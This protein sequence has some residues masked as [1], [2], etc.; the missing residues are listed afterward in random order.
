MGGTVVR[1]PDAGP[2]KALLGSW[3]RAGKERPNLVSATI[4]TGRLASFFGSGSPPGTDTEVSG[5]AAGAGVGV[6]NASP[7]LVDFC[8]S[9]NP[10]WQAR[11]LL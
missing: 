7:P 4:T 8:D 9:Q 2:G 10:T 5:I 3:K 11:K 6:Q 1:A